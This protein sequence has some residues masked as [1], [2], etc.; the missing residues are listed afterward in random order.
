M[1]ILYLGIYLSTWENMFGLSTNSNRERDYMLHTWIYAMEDSQSL[2][3]LI[4]FSYLAYTYT[5]NELGNG[6]GFV[7]FKFV[8]K[9]YFKD[10]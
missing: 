7:L 8:M 1:F 9:T 3:S 5:E 6:T 4:D 2:L 10:C